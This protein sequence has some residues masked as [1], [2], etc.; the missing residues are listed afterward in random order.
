VLHAW[1][2]VIL[3]QSLLKWLTGRDEILVLAFDIHLICS[4][5]GFKHNMRQIKK[6]VCLRLAYCLSVLNMDCKHDSHIEMSLSCNSSV[7]K[8][9]SVHEFGQTKVF[10]YWRWKYS[11]FSQHMN[12]I[13][14]EIGVSG[15]VILVH[16]LVWICKS[17]GMNVMDLVH[18]ILGNLLV[19]T[20]LVARCL[21][22]CKHASEPSGKI[23]N[24]LS[25]VCHVIMQKWP[26]SRHLCKCLLPQMY[27]KW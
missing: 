25:K 4:E 6:I 23:W 20:T 7:I 13:P 17:L 2:K 19:F 21:Y 15:T 11:L 1:Y 3:W 5:Y 27:D 10:L 18:C 9:A 16:S 26:L 14:N 8:T 22:V 24:Y 12:S